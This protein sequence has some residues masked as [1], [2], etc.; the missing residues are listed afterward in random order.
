MQVI[1]RKLIKIYLDAL[2]RKKHKGCFGLISAAK[3]NKTK[4]LGLIFGYLLIKH[5]VVICGLASVSVGVSQMC[6]KS[7]AADFH[8]D[9][10]VAMF[11]FKYAVPR[12]VVCV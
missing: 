12:H 7:T 5:T 10:V 8:D 3:Q 1:Q 6:R 9:D 2:C 4:K 11:S